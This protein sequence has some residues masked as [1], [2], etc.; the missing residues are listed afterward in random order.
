M[1]SAWFYIY[2]TFNTKLGNVN[3]FIELQLNNVQ[4]SSLGISS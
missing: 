1:L 2:H 4:P 3:L